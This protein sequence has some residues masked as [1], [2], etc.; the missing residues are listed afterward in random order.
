MA[1]HFWIKDL[2]LMLHLGCTE[3]EQSVPQMVAVDVVIN[4]ESEPKGCITDKLSDTLCYGHIAQ[5]LR[6]GV[7]GKRF[8]LIEHVNASLHKALVANVGK[9]SGVASVR[10]SVCKLAP[11]IEGLHGGVTF[12]CE[13]IWTTD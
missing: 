4:L 13:R 6:L 8:H 9:D 3:V 7:E 10:M 1:S 12:T 2:R 5:A 11:P